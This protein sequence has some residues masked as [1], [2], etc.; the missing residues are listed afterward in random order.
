MVTGG[1]SGRRRRQ[2]S[3]GQ[4][5]KTRSQALQHSTIL[6]DAG[7][8]HKTLWSL[9]TAP[10]GTPATR[11]PKVSTSRGLRDLSERPF[12]PTGLFVA[13][14]LFS[15]GRRHT[16]I[17]AAGSSISGREVSILAT[18]QFFNGLLSVPVRFLLESRQRFALPSPVTR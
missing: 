15:E 4:H 12:L 6:P 1:W 3:Y 5:V 17:A 16:R 9:R 7:R 10:T 18:E 11:N 13:T 8:R 14:V 2:E